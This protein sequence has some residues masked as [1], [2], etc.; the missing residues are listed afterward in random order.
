MGGVL[1]QAAGGCQGS[2]NSG[3]AVMTR[4]DRSD[5]PIPEGH[6]RLSEAFDAY[7]RKVT[8]NWEDLEK[9]IEA[10]QARRGSAANAPKISAWKRAV[11]GPLSK[12]EEDKFLGT[13]I[14]IAAKEIFLQISRPLSE[15][16][17]AFWKAEKAFYAAVHARELA[18]GR[19]QIKFREALS[20]GELRPMIRDPVTGEHLV[21][22]IQGWDRPRYNQDK[23]LLGEQLLGGFDSDF[24]DDW[25]KPGSPAVNRDCLRPVFFN[26]GASRAW[27]AKQGV[28]AANAAPKVGPD[29]G[30]LARALAAC[31]NANGGSIEA[32]TIE[33][34]AGPDKKNKGK[35]FPG[36]FK[37]ALDLI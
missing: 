5:D 18:R 30:R 9:A 31:H 21:L 35:S 3:G 29:G 13:R 16:E 32:S 7:Y 14:A 23:Q 10:A 34:A 26:D 2:A 20:S 25:D 8:P 1:Q 19:A 12:T 33:R 15:T 36:K 6:I 4:W 11:D 27:L 28:P 22:S 17:R 37:T 24:V